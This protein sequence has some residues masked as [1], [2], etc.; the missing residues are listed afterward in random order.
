MIG[1]I[2]PTTDF[3]SRI[4]IIW[5]DYN[6][7]GTYT[8]TVMSPEKWEYTGHIAAACIIS[9]LIINELKR[10]N[11]CDGYSVSDFDEKP[12][13]ANFKT[14]FLS[15]MFGRIQHHNPETGEIRT[16]AEYNICNLSVHYKT[17]DNPNIRWEYRNYQILK[18]NDVF[19]I[20][21]NGKI[22]ES[23]NSLDTALTKIDNFCLERTVI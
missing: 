23:C 16:V 5:R 11:R 9:N 19:T 3:S 13:R 12:Y 14:K 1:I 7:D 21:M 8:K 2:E 20:Y 10:L 4:V 22:I 6:S 17:Q 18:E 15:D